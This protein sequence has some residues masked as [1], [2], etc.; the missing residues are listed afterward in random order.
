MLAI[1]R[2]RDFVL[3]WLAGLISETGDWLLITGLPIY[4]YYLTGSPLITATV[5]II[6]MVPVILL[7]S[8]AGVMID[9]WNRRRAM[10]VIPL[11]QAALLAPLLFAHSTAD[12]WLIYVVAAGQAI[13]GQFF[14]P[15]RTSVLPTLVGPDQL[16]TANGLVGASANLGR[17][18]GSSLGGL[19]LVGGTLT[20]IV[21]ADAVTFLLAAALIAV[22]RFG[23]RPASGE[24]SRPVSVIRAWREGI[25][26]IAGHRG[27]RGTFVSMALGSVGQG[28][29]VVLFIVFVDQKLH[30]DS[31][32]IGLLRGVQAIGGL[33]GG[34]L[35]G[36]VGRRLGAH[37]ARSPWASWSSSSGTARSSRRRCRSTSGCSSRSGSRGCST[38][39]APSRTCSSR[40]RPTTWAGSW[41]HC[42]RCTGASRCWACSRRVCSPTM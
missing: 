40:Y 17:L 4:V 1:L 37:R 26:L 34:L 25:S 3:V 9:R 15:A 27:I 21:I 36:L 33:A 41:A 42:C 5:F 18:I 35:V 30:G 8:F 23:A 2:R 16:G 31:A 28:V 6:E 22:A 10:I 11:A 39:P 24:A 7:S 32:E 20:T 12:L 38:R 29:F 14:E 13:L 19:A